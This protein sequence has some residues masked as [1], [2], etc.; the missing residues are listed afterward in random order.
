MTAD[1][2]NLLL[3]LCNM[4]CTQEECNRTFKL[5]RQCEAT[6]FVSWDELN[7]IMEM[8]PP[9]LQYYRR[10]AMKT[11]GEVR[12]QAK[13][14][15]LSFA[16]FM[17]GLNSRSEEIACDSG[18]YPKRLFPLAIPVAQPAQPIISEGL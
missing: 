17:Y 12:L 9:A 18:S 16:D 7:V 5:I 13:A 8:C 11:F 10:Y 4:N 6:G 1:Q 14:M 15:Q 3:M 2:E